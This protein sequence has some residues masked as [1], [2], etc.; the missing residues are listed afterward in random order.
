MNIEIGDD[1]LEVKLGDNFKVY[2]Y[3]ET[4]PGN[5]PVLLTCAIVSARRGTTVCLNFAP[6]NFTNSFNINIIVTCSS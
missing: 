4:W 6:C 5:N 2:M 3:S 1:P